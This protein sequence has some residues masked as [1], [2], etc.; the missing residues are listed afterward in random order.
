MHFGIPEFFL[1]GRPYSFTDKAV[2]DNLNLE[3]T[4]TVIG[5]YLPAL[6]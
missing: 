6:I 4:G 1:L 5:E 2:M 3:F